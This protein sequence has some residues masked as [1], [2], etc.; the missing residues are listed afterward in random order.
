MLVKSV[1]NRVS[2]DISMNFKHSL[3]FIDLGAYFVIEIRVIDV[4]A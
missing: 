4:I 1:Q 3:A 2:L